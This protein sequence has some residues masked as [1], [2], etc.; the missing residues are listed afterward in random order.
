MRYIDKAT[1]QRVDAR[2]HPTFPKERLVSKREIFNNNPNGAIL[3]TSN[4]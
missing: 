2:E 3:P 1:G 4:T